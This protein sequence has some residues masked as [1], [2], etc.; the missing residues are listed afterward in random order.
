MTG[1]LSKIAST[2]LTR[3]VISCKKDHFKVLSQCKLMVS[4][5][6]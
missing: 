4:E 6:S 3:E 1:R 2:L 5:V